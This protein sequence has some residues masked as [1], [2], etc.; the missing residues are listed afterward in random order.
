MA[1][2]RL[3]LDEI[4]AGAWEDACR[5]DDVVRALLANAGARALGR[6][7]VAAAAQA[8]EIST[9][10]LYRMIARFRETRRVSSLMAK[11]RGRPIGHKQLH[12]DVEALIQSEI[13]SFYLRPERPS[14]NELVRQIAAKA[15][16]LGL[17]APALRTVKSRVEEIGGRQRARARQDQG[18]LEAMTAV[19]GVYEATRPLEVVQID[20][21]LSDIIV[22][23]EETRA[24][25]GRPWLTLAIDVFSR[26]VCG[27]YL[28]FDP[29]SRNAVGLCLLHAVF[30]KT[31]WLT[32]IGIDIPWPDRGPSNHG[33]R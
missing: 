14:L 8:L 26:M 18:A 3:A 2:N 1:A 19:P 22:V 32:G 4:D 10:T 27:F 30:D 20:H 29:P 12:P 17:R 23:D 13:K 9:A 7:Q 31:A 25:V 21:T 6:S 24:V 11:P 5:R 33:S 16:A 28:S 15:R